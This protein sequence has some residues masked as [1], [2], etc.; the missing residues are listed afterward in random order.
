M[1]R[2]VFRAP[3]FFHLAQSVSSTETCTQ[4]D[5][6]RSPSVT[7]S[8]YEKNLP[9]SAHSSVLRYECIHG[10]WACRHSRVLFFLRL[11]SI[12]CL[13]LFIPQSTV[14]CL[15]GLGH[16]H[17]A[18]QICLFTPRTTLPRLKRYLSPAECFGAVP[19]RQYRALSLLSPL[20]KRLIHLI[21]CRCTGVLWTAISEEKQRSCPGNC[22]RVILTDPPVIQRNTS[23]I[24][25]KR[26]RSR[27]VR[28]DWHLLRF[29]RQNAEKK[30]FAEISDTSGDL[31]IRQLKSP[32]CGKTERHR[33]KFVAGKNTPKWLSL[34][35]LN[36]LLVYS[37]FFLFYVR[38]IWFE[39][40]ENCSNVAASNLH[41]WYI[42]HH[43]LAY[44][45]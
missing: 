13:S 16:S 7:F 20:R 27:A 14:R 29:P 30:K 17:F 24:S 32:F 36:S 25:L 23:P 43:V 38:E 8:R 34:V 2:A 39:N 22:L 33:A 6:F 26:F 44:L 4:I 18:F 3:A 31:C 5:L 42:N 1:W 10:G 21:C 15:E 40:T 45:Q 12:I 37:H 35:T 41:V 19:P 11:S 28:R 9:S